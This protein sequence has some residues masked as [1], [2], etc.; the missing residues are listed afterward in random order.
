MDEAVSGDLVEKIIVVGTG[1]MVVLGSLI[2]AFNTHVK[3][4]INSIDNAVNHGR[5]ERIEAD[6]QAIKD[7]LEDG[8]KTFDRLQTQIERNDSENDRRHSEISGR[9]D[10]LM[11][12]LM[13]D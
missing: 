13:K 4:K 6:V 9:F 11:L 7:R 1:A 8:D 5:M 10:S 12:K 3:P 2:V